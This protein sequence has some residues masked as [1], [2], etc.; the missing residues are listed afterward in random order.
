MADLAVA[1]EDD[2]PPVAVLRAVMEASSSQQ[3]GQQ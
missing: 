3:E 2:E 1:R